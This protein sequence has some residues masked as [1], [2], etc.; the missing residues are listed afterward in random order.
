[1]FLGIWNNTLEVGLLRYV[2][3]VQLKHSF[4]HIIIIAIA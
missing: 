1:M 2:L 3:L 4:I